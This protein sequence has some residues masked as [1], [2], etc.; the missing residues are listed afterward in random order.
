MRGLSATKKSESSALHD[1][2]CRGMSSGGRVASRR[3]CCMKAP[4][5]YRTWIVSDECTERSKIPLE[6]QLPPKPGWYILRKTIEQVAAHQLLVRL[7]HREPIWL[8]SPS[9]YPKLA[10]QT[11]P[12][13]Q[14]LI[15]R[16]YQLHWIAF[17]SPHRH[18]GM[19]G[20]QPQSQTAGQGAIRAFL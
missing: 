7:R 5:L 2:A 12:K 8:P 17:E 15:D 6:S 4:V 20:Q 19:G 9:V 1:R 10:A 13:N 3:S 14:G 16:Q 11:F 18:Y